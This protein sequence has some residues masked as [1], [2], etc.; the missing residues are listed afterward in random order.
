MNEEERVNKKLQESWEHINPYMSDESVN[1]ELKEMCKICECWYGAK[2]D[3][4]E[5]RNKP[6]FR[7]WLAYQYLLWVTS[8]E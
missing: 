5:C 7:F 4:N 1:G 2:H 6:C 3:Y 8:W